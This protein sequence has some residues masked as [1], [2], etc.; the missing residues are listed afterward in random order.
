M[1]NQPVRIVLLAEIASADFVSLAKTGQEN[2]HR[3]G[4]EKGLTAKTEKEGA[5]LVAAQRSGDPG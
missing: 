4:S 5:R 1:T 3:K 2:V